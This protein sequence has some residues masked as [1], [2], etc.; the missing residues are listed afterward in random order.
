[1]FLGLL[2]PDLLV[3][4]MDPVPY[5]HQAEIVRKTLIFTVLL[6]LFDFLPL[7]NYVNV[8]SKTTKQK[9]FYKV[10]FLLAS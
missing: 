7:K 6:L 1:M 9:L 4:N 3:R 5:N 10:S 8:P 2:D